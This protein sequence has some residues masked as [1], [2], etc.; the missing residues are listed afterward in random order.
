MTMLTG[1]RRAAR[2]PRSGQ[3]LIFLVLLQ[4]VLLGAL[5]LA[6]D[7]GYN[8]VQRRTMQNAAD[9]GAPAG[10]RIIAMSDGTGTTNYRVGPT[11]RDVAQWNG[12][13]RSRVECQ[14]L[15]D[16]LSS[17]GSCPDYAAPI[18]AGSTGIQVTVSE[19]HSTFVMQAL[20][21]ATAR[22]GGTSAAQVQIPIEYPP[23]PFVVCG[24]DTTF[25]APTGSTFG[26]TASTKGI[27]LLDEA[28]PYSSPR[29][30]GYSDCKLNSGGTGACKKV[31]EEPVQLSDGQWTSRAVI[32][33]DAYYYDFS[34]QT[35]DPLNNPIDHA[36][37]GS[38]T[39]IYG[40]TFLLHAS[41]GIATCNI[42][43][44]KF[45]GVNDSGVSTTFPELLK[46]FA[47]PGNTTYG[48]TGPLSYGT[49]P[50]L[51]VTVPGLYGCKAGGVLDK[52][53]VLLPVIDNSGPGGTSSSDPRCSGSS[54]CVLV[55]IRSVMAFWVEQ[56]GQGEHTGK[57][58]NGYVPRG[59]GTTGFIPGV[60]KTYV[61]RLVK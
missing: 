17:N 11:V 14:Y 46:D 37:Q 41:N 36:P 47:G 24:V 15:K 9:A 38:S 34:G 53:V 61:V 5:G 48:L 39:K 1:L 7:G 54:S 22:T 42:T 18:P 20:G 60:T 55:G 49:T 52:C 56:T 51:T 30:D 31:K 59:A 28:N 21:I 8:F 57:L 4:G 50:N 43:A 35:K 58:V 25:T 12:V 33:N 32:N 19:V 10:A 44:S 3:T 2:R 29:A 16:D 26:S 45:K 6:L 40:P 23:S 27:F 13:D